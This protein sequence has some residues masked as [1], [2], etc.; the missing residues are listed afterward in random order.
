MLAL[1]L[2]LISHSSCCFSGED[3]FPAVTLLFLLRLHQSASSLYQCKMMW[4]TVF[5]CSVGSD[6][7]LSYLSVMIHVAPKMA[8]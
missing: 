7:V 5:S 1:M 2:Q 6:R 8:F 3:R 4:L